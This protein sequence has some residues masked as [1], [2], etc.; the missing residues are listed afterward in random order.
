MENI[1]INAI[2]PT[3]TYEGDSPFP[4]TDYGVYIPVQ[5]KMDCADAAATD[6]ERT[7]TI[8]IGKNTFLPEHVEQW[9]DII[10][11]ARLIAKSLE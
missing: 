7:I 2:S 1:I 6:I 5:V 4:G 9:V 10:K 3:V 11:Q 8:K